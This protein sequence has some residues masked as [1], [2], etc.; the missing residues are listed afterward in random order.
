MVERI[1]T[2]VVL[3]LHAVSNS[4]LDSSYS[5]FFFSL[6]FSIILLHVELQQNASR[7][8]RPLLTLLSHVRYGVGIWTAVGLDVEQEEE[9]EEEEEKEE[10]EEEAEEHP[11]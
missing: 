4:S 1:F 6:L 9:E 2:K 8:P 11:E 7:S 10:E 5:R 3:A